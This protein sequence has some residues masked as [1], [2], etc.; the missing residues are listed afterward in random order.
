MARTV[1]RRLYTDLYRSIPFTVKGHGSAHGRFSGDHCTLKECQINGRRNPKTGK[2]SGEAH[3]NQEGNIN[4]WLEE[5][6]L[7]T[8]RKEK[9]KEA[10]GMRVRGEIMIRDEVMASPL[11]A[12][13]F[14]FLVDHA[15]EGKG[16][17]QT[18]AARVL[19]ILNQMRG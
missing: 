9:K 12:S 6:G 8:T 13:I 10:E 15:V 17:E 18:N 4:D 19:S 2:V 7:P 11:R 14:S 5:R 16:V 3:T 1:S